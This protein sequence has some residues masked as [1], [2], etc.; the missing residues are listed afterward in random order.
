MNV[1]YLFPRRH[2]SKGIHGG[3]NDENECLSG[4]K[5][6]TITDLP[7]ITQ[8]LGTLPE[9]VASELGGHCGVNVSLY[10]KYA[11]FETEYFLLRTTV[12]GLVTLQ[13]MTA[14]LI[15]FHD[16]IIFHITYS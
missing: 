15:H 3:V 9:S 13:F 7:A 12:D 14:S 4:Y 1:K 16:K 8:Q 11:L 10:P 6:I 2:P 5:D